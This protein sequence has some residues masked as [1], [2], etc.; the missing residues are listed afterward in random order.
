MPDLSIDFPLGRSQVQVDLYCH[1]LP[2]L[3]PAT[4][5]AFLLAS[6]ITDSIVPVNNPVGHQIQVQ[7]FPILRFS[8]AQTN[9][10]LHIL[11]HHSE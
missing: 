9:T 11:N 4:L 3:K 6:N 8:N 7:T 2:V 5:I 1:F 10:V